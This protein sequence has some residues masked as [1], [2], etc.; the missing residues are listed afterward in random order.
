[1][2]YKQLL[3]ILFLP[4]AFSLSAKEYQPAFSAAGFYD[5]QNSGRQVY[6]F[7]V[8]WRFHKGDVAGAEKADFKDA[9]W[10]VVSTP[11]TV[12][13]EPA[14]ASGCRNYQGTAWYRKHFTLDKA[15]AG[16]K[17]ILY[18]EAV[19]GK[20]K[21]Y[22]NGKLVKQHLG[23]YLPFS[24][25]LL[26]AGAVPGQKCVVAVSTDNSDDKTY[27]PGKSQKTLDFLYHGGIY[28]DI[29]LVVKN[30][31]NISDP[32]EAGKVAG[33][34]VFVHYGEI[35]DKLADVFIDTDV[36]NQSDGAK[37]VRVETVLRDPQGNVVAKTVSGVSLRKGESKQVKQAVKV[38]NPVLWT[39][40]EPLL[41][42]V[43]SR[44]ISG[45]ASLDGGMTRI[46]IRKAE[47]R[48]VDGFYLNGKP[49]EKLIGGNRHQDFA[50]V[51][52]AVPNSQQWRDAKKLRDAGC[53]IIRSAHYPQDPSFMDACDE[54]GLFVIVPTPG[55]QFWNKD[56]EFAN[57]VYSDIRNMIRRDRNHTSVLMWEPILNETPFPLDFSL[58]AYKITKEEYPYPGRYDAAD[59]NS[60]GVKDNFEVVYGWPRDTGTVKQSIFTREWGEY[61][62]DW[63]A[64]NTPN[65][66]ARA[67][68][69]GPQ[70]IQAM[71]LAKIY[72][73][74][75]DAPTQF[76]GGCQWHPFDHQRG[77]HPDPYWGG[78]MD[79]FRQYKYSYYM[80]RS[81]IDPKK[82]HP[83]ADIKPVLYIASEISPFSS[84]DVT[85]FTNCDEVRLIRYERDT[86]VQKAPKAL[87]GMPHPPVTF[88]NA[89]DFYDMRQYPYVQKNWQRVSF[90][91]EG[92]IDGKVVVTETK[93]PSRRSTQIRLRIDNEGQQLTAD[94]S[95]FA[96]IIAEVTDDQGN[97]RRLA[98]E[99]I[100]FSVEGEGEI[101]G[102]ASIQAN[103]RVVE[104]GSAP[105][106]IRS[107]TKAGKIKVTARPL[108]EGE[109]A[110]KA[111]TLEFSS[112]TPS[113]TLLFEEKPTI[114]VVNQG[115]N[116]S[117]RKTLTDEEKQ[118][119][120]NEVERQ[121]TDFGEVKAN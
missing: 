98:K 17:V 61:V 107:T 81:Q 45:K 59:L 40:D 86:L 74:M 2:K 111:A 73:E 43:E 96:C 19:M 18:F 24:I 9:A 112:V 4:L 120:L 78:I 110:P 99:Q 41:Y 76:V 105:V 42:H 8:G 117:T 46:G 101:I 71:H 90:K 27:P 65:R 29:W 68:G 66:A 32:N 118:K 16:K 116:S 13:L 64:H 72:N 28:R 22:L 97:V 94:G 91:A 63:Y 84:P 100:L 85:V 51:G 104:F 5:L 83:L 21:V 44:V 48:G 82:P 119:L 12:E 60:K 121:Q 37:S 92:L 1:M 70:L 106:L 39:P 38:K 7:N 57:L 25:D 53:R 6:N 3:L 75:C 80:F 58:N 30:Q 50:Y 55:W 77:Y 103:P 62:D 47:F 69:E 49:Y 93:M 10:D 35:N 56:P 11:H 14:E 26:E 87:R 34:G 52:N 115:P 108:F 23:G 31:I 109:Y 15:Y 95:D 33:G 88:K 67:W 36:Q 54:L 113:R 89:Y 114:N 79:N 102:D 20:C